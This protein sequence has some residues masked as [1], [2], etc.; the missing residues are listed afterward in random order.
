MVTP[1]ATRQDQPTERS[2][3]EKIRPTGKRAVDNVSV[4]G[5]PSDISHASV[6]IVVV[7]IKDIFEGHKSAEEVASGRVNDSLRLW[8][9]SESAVTRKA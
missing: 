2:S 5:D 9:Q 4:T 6:A 3:S 8:S 7:N 1:S